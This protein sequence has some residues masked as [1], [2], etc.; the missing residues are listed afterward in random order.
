MAQL[1]YALQWQNQTRH[2]NQLAIKIFLGQFYI[3]SHGKRAVCNGQNNIQ[4]T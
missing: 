3:I 2:Y 1:I 4:L